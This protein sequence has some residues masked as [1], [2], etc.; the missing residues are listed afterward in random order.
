MVHAAGSVS[1]DDEQVRTDDEHRLRIARTIRVRRVEDIRWRCFRIARCWFRDTVNLDPPTREAVVSD[2]RDIQAIVRPA[3]C[4][5]DVLPVA[6]ANR[7]AYATAHGPCR[8]E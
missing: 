1:R 5:G 8:V 7:D 4:R 3:A 6:R 2:V